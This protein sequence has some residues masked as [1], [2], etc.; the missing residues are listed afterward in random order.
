METK[1]N[2][3]AIVRTL[4]MVKLTSEQQDKMLNDLYYLLDDY[5]Q[6]VAGYQLNSREQDQLSNILNK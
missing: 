4:V 3:M 6:E 1:E 5:F 2:I